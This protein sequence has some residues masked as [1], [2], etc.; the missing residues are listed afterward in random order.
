MFLGSKKGRLYP[1]Q[2]QSEK[3]VILWSWITRNFCCITKISKF[4]EPEL[5]SWKKNPPLT[6]SPHPKPCVSFYIHEALLRYL[7]WWK[8]IFYFV[9][10]YACAWMKKPVTIGFTESFFA[11]RNKCVINDTSFTPQHMNRMD[12]MTNFGV[13][14]SFLTLP[15]G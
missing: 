13:I 5:D 1:S 12:S 4:E 3:S 7:W 2:P 8:F 10:S 11:Y 9:S 6:P 14:F 15:G